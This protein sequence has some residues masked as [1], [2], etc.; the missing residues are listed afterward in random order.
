M[1]E[2]NN[3]LS[4]ISALGRSLMVSYNQ[5]M[6]NVQSNAPETEREIIRLHL[7]FLNTCSDVVKGRLAELDE[8][9]RSNADAA[10]AGAH[11][12]GPQTIDIEAD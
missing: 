4:A 10:T 8:A 7:S 6:Q 3:L 12:G 1:N 11:R 5:Y 2:F 9:A